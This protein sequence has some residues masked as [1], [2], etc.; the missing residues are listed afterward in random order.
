MSVTRREFLQTASLVAAASPMC[1]A[2]AFAPIVIDTH[3]HCFAGLKD[4]RFPYHTNAPYRPASVAPP[5]KLLQC[6]DGAGVNFAIVVHPEP[7]QDDHRYLEYCLEV[8]KGRVKGTC[9]VFAD[10]PDSM[11]QLPKLAKRGDVVAV[12]MHAYAP[13]RLP[14]FGKPEMRAFW[15]KASDL[16]LAVQLHI[17]PRYAPQFEPFIRDFRSTQVIVDHLGRP[18]QGTPEEHAVIVRWSRLP[19]VFIKLAALPSAAEYP[20]RDI[21]P[22]VRQVVD[23]YGA[24]RL[25]YGGGFGENATPESYRAARERIRAHLSHL[26]PEDQAKVMGTNAEKLFGFA[27]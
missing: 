17:E 3:L 8:G 4:P 1:N 12:R 22:I 5:E 14:P 11:A 26:K 19:N 24:D 2:H 6:M 20:Y 23:A 15:K 13:E 16:G 25:I 7:Y 10:R 27:K 9:L 18:L 21:A